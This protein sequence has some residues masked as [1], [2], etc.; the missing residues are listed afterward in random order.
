MPGPIVHLIVQQRLAAA[1]RRHDAPELAK[2]LEA[3]T[4]DPYA[5]FGSMGPDFLF[6]SLTEYGTPLDELINFIFDVYDALEPLI[7]FYEDHIEPVVDSIEDAIAAVDQ[8]LFQ[9]LFA[10]IK[11]TADQLT[12]TAL[13][14]AAAALTSGV[15][16]FY[17]FYPKLQQGVPE[18]EWY[19]F[20]FLHYRRT[21]QFASTMWNLAGG[22]DELER[23]V[24]GYISHIGN[25]VTGHPF[26][27]AVVGGPFRT[28]W[29][30]HKLVENWIDAYARNYDP[31]RDT[32]RTIK[33]LN[34]GEDDTY[35][36][37]SISGSYYS[38]LV[39]FPNG[40][41]PGK[42]EDLLLNA[43]NQT[44][45][46]VPEHPGFFNQGDLDSTYRLWLKWFTR[47]TSIGSGQPPAFVPPPGGATGALISDYVS[48]F[49]SFPGGGGA[50]G[51]GGFSLTN[52]LAAILAFAQ[53]VADVVSYTVD[54]II[55]HAVDIITLPFTEA[56]ALIRWLLYQVQKGIFE[57]Y[58]NLRF[59]LVL[60]AY[61]F[62]ERRDLAKLPWGL[63]L[64]NTAHAHL[65]G[66][67]TASFF[68]YPRKQETHGLIGT[69]EHHLIYPGVL[70]ELQHAEPMPDPFHGAF[71]EVF[72]GASHAYNPAIEG[73]YDA[74]QPYGPPDA[75][76]EIDQSTWNTP[77]LGSALDFSA[78]LIRD[79]L[80]DL[81]NFNLDGDRGYGWKTWR[82][83]DP[84][85]IE[86][87]N[88]V[89]VDY[90]DA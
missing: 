34:L 66:G 29:H 31:Y 20:D 18:S 42:L 17:P 2:R 40:Q 74:K 13:T 83:R 50:P 30:R 55:N 14:A 61:L 67:A 59:A 37:D 49:P 19:W 26:V 64:L 78:R 73:L 68:A 8:A 65:S 57:V 11:A 10:Q 3:E 70:Q 45:S 56:I 85:T 4:C 28:H 72:I 43:M 88:P 1:L 86:T 46:G 48:G 75:T 52:I 53:W 71:P 60:G 38:R 12:A 9:G 62:P 51:G 41:L 16:L 24:L 79:R 21:G 76:H 44:F 39:E 58:D 63:C 80:T 90:I 22:D 5:A 33:C 69:T 27:N 25:D 35:L 36:A 87:S 54:W 15:D 82:A 89:P 23:Y 7:Q 81:P 32:K 77:Q 47:S 6:F 84:R